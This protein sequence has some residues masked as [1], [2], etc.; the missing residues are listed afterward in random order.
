MIWFLQSKVVG[1]ANDGDGVL[2]I[3]VKSAT[4]D[5]SIFRSN[6]FKRL[7]HDHS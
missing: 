1:D 2:D 4:G 3:E 7:T 6:G 5:E